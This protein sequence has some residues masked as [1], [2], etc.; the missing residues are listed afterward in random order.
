MNNFFGLLEAV[1]SFFLC[2]RHDSF[3]NSQRLKGLRVLEIPQ[4]SYARWAC[5][6]NAVHLFQTCF[7]C[8]L[9]AL[10]DTETSRDRSAAAESHGLMIQL[11]SVSFLA[12][13]ILRRFWV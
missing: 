7:E 3:V 8:L 10:D 6:Y 11:N 12:F 2:L 1:Y 5:C 4:L 13:C 9:E